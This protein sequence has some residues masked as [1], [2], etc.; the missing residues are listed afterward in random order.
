MEKPMHDVEFQFASESISE[1]MRVPSRR[2]SADENFPVLKGNYV[3]GSWLVHEFSVKRGD[4]TVRN[5]PHGD[6][7]QFPQF[8]TLARQLKTKPQG[9]C[10][11]FLKIRNVERPFSL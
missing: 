3:G 7:R 1:P 5:D 4:P 10:G 2:F 6:F 11:K 9:F 8:G